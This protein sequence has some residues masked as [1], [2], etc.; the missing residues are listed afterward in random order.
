MKTLL[1]FKMLYYKE[2]MDC[3]RI[4]CLQGASQAISS[5][6]ITQVSCLKSWH[7][8]GA[9]K[10]KNPQSFTKMQFGDASDLCWEGGL[11]RLFV[12]RYS[13]IQIA[14]KPLLLHLHS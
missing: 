3:E 14:Q 12:H 8:H 1:V 7:Q 2:I 13:H 6:S 10:A 4:F 5:R 9:L 11:R